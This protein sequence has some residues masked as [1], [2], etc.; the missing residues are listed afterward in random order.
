MQAGLV[1]REGE[2]GGEDFGL[3]EAIHLSVVTHAVEPKTLEWFYRQRRSQHSEAIGFLN[4]CWG[5]IP[6]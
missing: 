3:P 1:D 5:K 2:R 6:A 4:R